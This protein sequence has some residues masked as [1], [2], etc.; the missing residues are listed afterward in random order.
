MNN[1]HELDIRRPP[2][3]LPRQSSRGTLI[4][5]DSVY[6]EP[7]DRQPFNPSN[8]SRTTKIFNSAH[9][10]RNLILKGFLRW[11]GTLILTALI[12]LTLRIHEAKRNFPADQKTV[13]NTIITAWIVGFGL[14]LFV[15]QR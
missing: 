10:T 14:N 2:S 11:I 3:L 5:E 7:L 8:S 6:Q 12:A 15:S 9:Q 4:S 13:F 1:T